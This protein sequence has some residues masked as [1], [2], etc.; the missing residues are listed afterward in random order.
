MQSEIPL[1]FDVGGGGGFREQ[2]LGAERMT[3][4]LREEYRRELDALLHHRLT[5]GTRLLTWAG[6]LA[7]VATAVVC[8]QAAIRYQREWF[9][10]GT[11]AVV[12]VLVALWFARALWQGGFARRA[13]FAVVEWLG[14]AATSAFVLVTLFRGIAAPAEP[15]SVFGA[16]MAIMLMMTGFAWGTGNRITAAKMETREH[17]LRLESRLADLTERLQLQGER[18]PQGQQRTT[19]SR[20]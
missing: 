8:T 9:V 17:L 14:G 13:S 16:L 20:S 5:P 12:G 2:L 15:G 1:G 19:D 3:P 10:N 6:L 4:A 18:E 7:A 11:F